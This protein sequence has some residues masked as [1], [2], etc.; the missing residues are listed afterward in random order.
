MK[1]LTFT[2][3]HLSDRAFKVLQKK[4]KLHK[5]DLI[6]CC[7]DHT[8]FDNESS[9][10]TK[11][12]AALGNVFIIHG[13]HESASGVRKESAKYPRMTFI[14][15]KIAIV[16][17][18]A[19]IGWGGGGFQYDYPEFDKFIERNVARLKGKKLVLVTHA[20]PYNTTLDDVFGS[21]VGSKT[22]IRFVK[23]YKNQLVA[24]FCGHIHECMKN[25]QKVGKCLMLN[26]GA[27]G[28]VVE[29]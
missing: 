5:P 10:I 19:F 12:I 7:G 3:L 8:V 20:P 21:H 27:D 25:T 28:M 2:D 4:A 6:I 17:E 18:Y 1:I 11:K 24:Y 23:K 16:N 14:H 22:F 9:K 15:K 26:P 29:I 13:N